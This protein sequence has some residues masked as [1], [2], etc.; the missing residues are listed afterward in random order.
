MKILLIT[1][2]REAKWNKASF[3]TLAAAQ[4]IA[5]Q[6]KSTLTVVVIGNGV[7]A[8]AEE[9]AGGKLDEVLLVEHDTGS[10]HAR[11]IAVA[12]RR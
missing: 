2:Q 3:E 4:Q 9:L 7:A 10:L 11:W 8:L 1:E 5:Q 12:H 6:T